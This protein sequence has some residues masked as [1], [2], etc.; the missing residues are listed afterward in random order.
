MDQVWLG[1][2][3]VS[4]VESY[5]RLIEPPVEDGVP[6]GGVADGIVPVLHGELGGENGAASGI[7]IVEDFEQIVPALA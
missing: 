4:L 7:A 1:V 5:S 2:V 3:R 6:E